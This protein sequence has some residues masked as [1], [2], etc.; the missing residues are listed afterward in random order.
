MQLFTCSF[1]TIHD[2]M[3]F[4]PRR[5]RLFCGQMSLRSTCLKILPPG[6]SA[7]GAGQHAAALCLN[8]RKIGTLYHDQPMTIYQFTLLNQQQTNSNQH[9]HHAQRG[10]MPLRIQAA[11]MGNPAFKIR[12][13]DFV[14]R[15]A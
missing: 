10:K 2:I 15:T 9:M 11:Q 3:A 8:C 12:C 5:S 7:A 1:I 14:R 4:I 13:P 6:A